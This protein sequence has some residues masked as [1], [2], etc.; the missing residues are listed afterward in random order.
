MIVTE[1]NVPNI[2]TVNYLYEGEGG[3][4]KVYLGTGFK[5]TKHLS[6]GINGSYIFGT[7]SNIKSVEFEEDY[8][9]NS[10]YINSVTA[11]G[12][13]FTYGLLYDQPLKNELQLSIGL[14]GSL[15]SKL[16]A[17]N[18]KNYFNY[19]YNV[20]SGTDVLKDSVINESSENGKIQMPDYFR[21][22][23]TIGKPKNW[24]VGFDFS[25]YNWAN[26]QSFDTNDSL[27]NSY[28]LHIGG[29]KYGE[30]L[31]YRLGAKYGTTYLNIKNT[32]LDEYGVTV[33]IGINKLFPKRPPS[34][35]NIAFELGQRGTL[36][37]NL[38]K[39]SYFKFHLGFT[40]TDIWFIPA[41]YD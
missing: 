37:N 13:Y 22:G 34:T 17:V 12:F 7:I 31:I 26:F 21:I 28:T 8:Y 2:G 35:V 36:D 33:G 29:E 15:S 18:D 24:T 40:L 20:A 41:K 19:Y 38:I 32:Q 1:N 23:A 5:I 16:N 9:F 27:D 25:Y 30:K 10:R 14:T 3:F 11:K 4:N 6:A 39:E